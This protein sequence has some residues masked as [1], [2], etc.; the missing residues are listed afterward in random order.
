[1][2]SVLLQVSKQLLFVV[3]FILFHFAPTAHAAATTSLQSQIDANTQA[4]AQLNQEIAT[5]EAEI[6]KA[7]SDKKT[8][9]SAINA[10]NL[11]KSAGLAKIAAAQH[12]ISA[13]QLQIQQLGG[14]IANT[15]DQIKYQRP[16]I[17]GRKSKGGSLGTIS[18]E[19]TGPQVIPDRRGTRCQ[20]AGARAFAG[21]CGYRNGRGSPDGRKV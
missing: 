3:I 7:G 20:C 19:C 18:E 6:A 2:F 13:T 14:T 17:K 9:Q 5:Y 10:L 11:Q 16:N 8:L 1:M 21:E 12:Q 15:E 4:V